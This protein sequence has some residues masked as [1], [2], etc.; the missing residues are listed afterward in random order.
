MRGEY[1][2]RWHGIRLF[3]KLALAEGF[4][5]NALPVS[6]VVTQTPNLQRTNYRGELTCPHGWQMSRTSAN[7]EVSLCQVLMFRANLSI[8]VSSCA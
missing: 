3:R 8:T 1:H 6:L 4:L 2:P 7:Y 5:F